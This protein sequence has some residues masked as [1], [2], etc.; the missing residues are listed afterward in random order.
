LAKRFLPLAVGVLGLVVAVGL[1]ARPRAVLAAG[2]LAALL[3]AA[4]VGLALSAHDRARKSESRLAALRASEAEY[5]LMFDGNPQPMWIYEASSLRFLAVNEAAVREYGYARSEFLGMTLA[6]IRPDEDVGELR[7]RVAR[8]RGVITSSGVWRHRRKDG[9]FLNVEVNSYPITFGDSPAR[10]V[11]AWDVTERARLEEQLRHAQKLEA[12]GQLAGG[13]AHDFNNLL[14]VIS[15]YGDLLRKEP[16]LSE[17]ARRRVDQVL[18]AAERAGGLTRQ[19]LA[20]SRKQVLQPRVLDLNTVVR[21][22]EKMLGRLI[23]EN[24]QLVTS[25]SGTLGK[26][27]ADPGQI[28]QI[29]MNLAVNARDAMPAGGR[30][31]IET[32]D[33]QLDSAY[34]GSY[35]GVESGPYVML[36]VSDTGHGMTPEVQARIFEPFFTT[37]PAGE[38]TG[39]G[40]PT[41]HGI[42]KQSGGHIFV[43]S[44]PGRGTAFK[45]YLPRLSGAAEEAADTAAADA[46]LP[47]GSETVL[48]VEDEASLRSIVRE[49]LEAG[50]YSVLEARHAGDALDMVDGRQLP[51]DLLIT[52]VIMPGLSG[53]ELA[54]RLVSSRPEMKVLY[55]S[56]YTDDA[57]VRHGVLG[58]EM[59]FLQK[60]FTGGA[61]VRK[62]RQTLDGPGPPGPPALGPRPRPS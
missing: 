57:V 24:V 2:C 25:L 28:E 6:D 8:V 62:V 7:E 52:D 35:A 44:E 58:L 51:V 11:Q 61:L 55:M 43:Y 12:V 22:T 39:L 10:M 17:R 16:G 50:G 32:V 36:A 4:L 34:A 3:F 19:L 20:F 45:I 27:K 14:G 56:G 60:P 31:T 26:V 33:T 21:E 46:E 59:P 41:V 40:L 13:V 49:C 53:R 15:G 47:G 18:K 37:K 38:G 30:L 42:V 5:R 1:S 23:S 48:L 54:Q 9:T 29:L